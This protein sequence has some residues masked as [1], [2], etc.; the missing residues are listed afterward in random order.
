MKKLSLILCLLIVLPL[1]EGCRLKVRRLNKRIARWE[2]LEKKG[3]VEQKVKFAKESLFFFLNTEDLQRGRETLVTEAERL[4][5]HQ[6]MSR[7]QVFLIDYHAGRALEYLDRDNDWEAAAAE[8]AKADSLTYG[9]L[10]GARTQY[11]MALLQTGY[12]EY[13]RQISWE[14][15]RYGRLERQFPGL[16]AAFRKMSEYQF[17][18]AGR[19]ES[20]GR[21]DEAIEHYLLVFRRDPDNFV[22]A[23][24]SLKLHT[25]RIIREFYDKQ[26]RRK[27][28]LD[29]FNNQRMELYGMVAQQLEAAYQS[30][31]D[32]ADLVLPDII[33]SM[34]E[35]LKDTPERIMDLYLISRNESEGTLNQYLSLWR[36]KVLKGQEPIK[37]RYRE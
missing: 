31:G 25:G 32:S 21:L 4:R 13:L 11:T 34:A 26:F 19:L 18:L 20:Q 16:M 5:Y 15:F 7:M 1:A 36:Y 8:W 2:S 35:R 23:N 10:P 30:L 14:G 28:A 22:K 29:G 33:A 17:R 27:V 9:F 37:P 24:R 12:D 3:T 6:I